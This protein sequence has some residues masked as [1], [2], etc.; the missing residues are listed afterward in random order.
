MVDVHGA[1]ARVLHPL[2]VVGAVGRDAHAA[3][4]GCRFSADVAVV[5][6]RVRAVRVRAALVLEPR[7]AAL[8]ALAQPADLEHRVKLCE[9][10]QRCELALAVG[11]ERV[12]ERVAPALDVVLWGGDLRINM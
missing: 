10:L 5:R 12:V 6:A 4:H 11:V 9:E 2:H 8:R 7:G 3:E 1:V